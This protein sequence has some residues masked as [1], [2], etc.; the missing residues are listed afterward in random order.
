MLDIE[1]TGASYTDEIENISKALDKTER[2]LKNKTGLDLKLF[3]EAV[4]A[5]IDDN[6]D[7]GP[8]C[9]LWI[10]AEHYFAEIAFEDWASVPENFSL[11]FHFVEGKQ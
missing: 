11:V 7:N 8:F 10:D 2:F 1:W 3:Y 6:M 5:E 4:L 9:D